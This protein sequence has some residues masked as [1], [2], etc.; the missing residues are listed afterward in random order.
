[1]LYIYILIKNLVID[2]FFIAINKN[3]VVPDRDREVGNNSALEW[4]LEDQ[5]IALLETLAVDTGYRFS[6]HLV[7]SFYYSIVIKKMY[8]YNIFYIF[9]KMNKRKI[10]KFSYNMQ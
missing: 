9:H 3:N 2:I 10:N 1:M 6:F 8:Q 7:M 5:T 4:W